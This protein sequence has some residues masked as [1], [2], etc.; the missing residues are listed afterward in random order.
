MHVPLLIWVAVFF[1]ILATCENLK[2]SRE[3]ECLKAGGK[4][5]ATSCQLQEQIE[6]K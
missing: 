5:F 2:S 4:W 3:L 1:L 6:E